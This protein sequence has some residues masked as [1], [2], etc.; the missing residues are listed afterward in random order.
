[1]RDPI[2]RAH[3]SHYLRQLV[4]VERSAFS[5]SLGRLIWS[6]ALSHWRPQGTASAWCTDP[7]DAALP[8]RWLLLTWCWMTA[9]C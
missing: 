4:Y 9:S 8:I 1:M 6:A 5:Y 7:A 2:S 3:R